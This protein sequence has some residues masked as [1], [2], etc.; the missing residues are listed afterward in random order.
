MKRKAALDAVSLIKKKR[1]GDSKG[2][3]C[4]NGAKQR[5]YV[6]AGEITYS[7]TLSLVS[8]LIP[9][10]IDAY[11]GRDVAIVA[12]PGAY[13]HADMPQTE[14]E[15]VLL[16]LKGDF[17]NIMCSVNEQFTHHV[18]YEGKTKVLSI[19]VLRA[20]YGCLDSAMLWYNLYVTTLKGMGFELNP[21]DL[22]VANK[23][24]NGKQCTIVWYVDG[25]KIS[26]DDP[27]VVDSIIQD[28]TKL[29]GELSITRG[30]EHTFLGMN[31]K[32]RDDKK[33]EIDMIEQI[34]EDIE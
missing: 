33:I 10:A 18:V 14:G 3:T 24:T 21:Y 17:V 12:V 4:Y 2:R 26:H 19:K 11:E 25:N 15:T 28:L 22:C 5:R 20:I 31:I 16:K 8:I 27:T 23:I 6:K 13:L 1:N 34:K 7:P 9:L 30:K 29:F 32:F